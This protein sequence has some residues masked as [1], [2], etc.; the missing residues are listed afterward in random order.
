MQHCFNS[1]NIPTQFL[2]KP[3]IKFDSKTH[4]NKYFQN[5][6]IKNIMHRLVWEIKGFQRQAKGKK[7]MYVSYKH[8]KCNNLHNIIHLISTAQHK[9]PKHKDHEYRKQK[10]K[11]QVATYLKPT[12]Y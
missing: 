11:A 9:Q 8:Q 4:S 6:T 5:S 3:K 7:I 12:G 10:T 2:S 1:R